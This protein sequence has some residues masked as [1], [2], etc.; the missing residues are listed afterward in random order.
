MEWD[1][2]ETI[3]FHDSGGPGDNRISIFR[4]SFLKITSSN[5]KACLQ[6]RILRHAIKQQYKQTN[7]LQKNPTKIN[8]TNQHIL[9]WFTNPLEQ[10][11]EALLLSWWNFHLPGT[12]VPS[13][14]RKLTPW[15]GLWQQC[16]HL[17]N[18]L[19]QRQCRAIFVMTPHL[20]LSN[21]I[22][23]NWAAVIFWFENK[24]SL[25]TV[26]VTTPW[27]CRLSHSVS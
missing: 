22:V 10:V 3:F 16:I 21:L 25:E 6:S 8:F 12:R 11:L 19:Y 23:I 9:N 5:N 13:W 2:K 14:R 15:L 7:K 1:P 26:A 24:I 20:I 17:Q 4:G 18:L 27:C